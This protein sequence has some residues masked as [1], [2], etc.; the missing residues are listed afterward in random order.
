MFIKI[1]VQLHP[2]FKSIALSAVS[3]RET[4]MIRSLITRWGVGYIR[5]GGGR[6]LFG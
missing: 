2:T 1:V 6:K 5:R 4:A 3:L